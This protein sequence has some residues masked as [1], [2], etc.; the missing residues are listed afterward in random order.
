MSL[1]KITSL[2]NKLLIWLL[3][4]IMYITCSG[5]ATPVSASELENSPSEYESSLPGHE[6]P[7]SEHESLPYAEA[8]NTLGVLRGNEKGLELH[9]VPTRS[10]VLVMIIRLLGKEQEALESTYSHPFIDTK[11]D[12]PY[13]SYGYNHSIVKGVS[14]NSF[15][16]SKQ[17]SLREY[18]TM[19]L[20]VLGYNE[21]NGDF[22]FQNSVRFASI[23]LGE[24]LTGNEKFD[25]GKM[26][27]ITCFALNTRKK[28][29]AKTLGKILV[30]QGVFTQQ[31]LND[32]QRCWEQREKYESTTVLIYAVGSDLESKQER[33]TNDLNEILLAAP[34]ENCHV[35]LQTGGTIQ[36]HNDW[37]TNR[38]AERFRVAGKELR[39]IDCNITTK[40][41][42]PQT[43]TDFIKWGV[44][45]APSQRYILVLW[46]HGYGIKGG[47]GADELNGNKTM[48]VSDI[49]AAIAN[50]G[51]FFDIIAFDACLM[52]TVETAYALRYHTKY[53]IASEEATPACGLYYTTWIGAL[54]RNPAISTKRLGRA[55]LD[56]FIIH[57]GIEANIPTSLAMMDV[58]RIQTLIDCMTLFTGD[59]IQ[60]ARNSELLGK[61]EGVFDQFDLLS[62]MQ[63]IPEITAAAQALAS[64]VRNSSD[65]GRY[66]GVGLYVPVYK[67][68]DKPLVIE[69]LEK[70][71]FSKAYLN[72]LYKS[73]P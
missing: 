70:V 66:C 6:N 28:D 41:S 59:L 37:M 19:L 43:L 42:D 63:G 54:E 8:L 9:R 16:G 35:L 73:I 65:G 13:V 71:G 72:T 55:I 39:R 25:R 24:E 34:N 38:K 1:E 61:N 22:T 60:S 36:Y 26:A 49:S 31:Q 50:S 14:A 51:V 56:S 30:E 29:S 32:A 48:A 47:F 18:C 23:V 46:D 27:E 52:G 10:E 69:E 15:G 53:L 67:P 44:K 58:R 12:E 57:A 20:R 45:E 5:T 64:E 17:A 4:C 2:A 11:W 3:I 62:V 68:E 33:L 21:S 7:A 40:A